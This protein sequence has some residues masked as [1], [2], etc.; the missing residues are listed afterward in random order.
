MVSRVLLRRISFCRSPGHCGGLACPHG[1]NPGHCS[2]YLLWRAWELLHTIRELRL[3]T[4]SPAVLQQKLQAGKKVAVLDLLEVEG[5]ENTNTIPGIS[6]A[7]RISPAALRSSTRVHVP[8]DVQVVLYCSSP[9]QLASARTTLALR[10]KGISN[11]WAQSMAGTRS[12][13]NY[14]PAQSCASCCSFRHQA[15]GNRIA[16]PHLGACVVSTIAVRLSV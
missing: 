13:C 1:A 9:N 15:A 11:V 4:I 14:G 16:Y 10:R 8:A 12:A 7:A 6:G 5:Q 2:C 3:R